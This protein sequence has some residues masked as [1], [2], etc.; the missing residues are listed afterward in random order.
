M[1]MLVSAPL[2]K[3]VFI[4]CCK[5]VKGKTPLLRTPPG[6][7]VVQLAENVSIIYLKL[8]NKIIMRIYFIAP[9]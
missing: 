1:L 3:L 8:K 5:T 2:R 6:G 9:F 7:L 4:P